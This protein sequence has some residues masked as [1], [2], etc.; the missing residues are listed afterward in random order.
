LGLFFLSLVSWPWFCLEPNFIR[1]LQSDLRSFEPHFSAMVRVAGKNWQCQYLVPAQSQ[2]FSLISLKFSFFTSV[3]PL[4]S[5]QNTSLWVFE[6]HQCRAIKKFML[7]RIGGQGDRPIPLVSA[8]LE[9]VPL[10]C[11]TRRA[12][13][14]KARYAKAFRCSTTSARLAVMT[15][16][17]NFA[18]PP[19]EFNLTE[20]DLGLW[21]PRTLVALV[22]E[23]EQTK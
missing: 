1:Q 5:D 4:C 21:S 14:G 13:Q 18:L 11:S 2:A 12:V 8:M 23:R 20:S 19:C 7:E 15:Q 10:K 22:P 6:H 3:K 17:E 9:H 16:Q